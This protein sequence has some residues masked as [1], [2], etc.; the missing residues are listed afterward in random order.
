MVEGSVNAWINDG[1]EA[2][3]IGH[4]LGAR[5]L[6][7]ATS[8]GAT[9]AT[10]LASQVSPADLQA[11]V[12]ISPNFG[13]RDRRSEI[14]LLPWG[15]QLARWIV[16]PYHGF[17]PLNE[18]QAQRWTT[19]YPTEAL[20][21]MMGLVELTRRLDLGEIEIPTLLFYSSQDQIVDAEELQRR[22]ALFGGHGNVAVEIPD[23]GD[24]THHVLT[25]DTLSPGTTA[26]VVDRIISFMADRERDDP[27]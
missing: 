2:L 23:S 26:M 7:I 13:P 25:G 27:E 6:L 10:W 14:L 4:R 9:L 18:T 11:M 16:G 19:R 1:V 17:E 15:R 3:E 20:L 22:F 24:P 8:T 5:V 21:P 12:L